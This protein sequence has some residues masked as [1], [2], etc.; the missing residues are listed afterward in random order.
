MNPCY[1]SENFLTLIKVFVEEESRY[2]LCSRK[3]EMEDI[4]L[5]VSRGLGLNP[6][7]KW[8]VKAKKYSLSKAREIPSWEVIVGV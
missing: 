7:E 2:N 1:L 8:E 3:G 6:L 4:A 5:F